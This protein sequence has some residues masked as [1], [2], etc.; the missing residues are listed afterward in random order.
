LKG[1]TEGIYP[2]KFEFSK[3]YY[4]NWSLVEEWIVLV[5]KDCDGEYSRFIHLGNLTGV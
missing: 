3:G 5:L 2:H 1:G 4:P